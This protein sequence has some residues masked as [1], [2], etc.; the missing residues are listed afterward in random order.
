MEEVHGAYILP[1]DDG[2]I[3]SL[4]GTDTGAV[5][6]LYQVKSAENEAH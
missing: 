2:A 4:N 6:S 1:V 5:K 3:I